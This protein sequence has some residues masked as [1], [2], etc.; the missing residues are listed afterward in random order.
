MPELAGRIKQI[1]TLKPLTAN[2]FRNIINAEKSDHLSWV[3]LFQQVCDRGMELPVD[4]IISSVST[5]E[6]GARGLLQEVEK[7]IN[8]CIEKYQDTLTFY[9]MLGIDKDE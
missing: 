1:I 4:K 7:E 9:Q 8:K 2:D 5:K 6:L 3:T